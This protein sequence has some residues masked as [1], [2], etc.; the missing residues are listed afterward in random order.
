MLKLSNVPSRSQTARSAARVAWQSLA[1]R[2]R[3]LNALTEFESAA[4][5]CSETWRRKA[6]SRDPERSGMF[7]F[8]SVLLDPHTASLATR[9]AQRSS[10]VKARTAKHLLLSNVL[11]ESYTALSTMRLAQILS[12]IRERA[13]CS[14]GDLKTLRRHAQRRGAERNR[15]TIQRAQR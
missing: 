8:S 6:S 15:A 3:V 4:V 10:D 9:L 1:L 7:T 11:S 13:S 5:P 14:H 12:V 2:E